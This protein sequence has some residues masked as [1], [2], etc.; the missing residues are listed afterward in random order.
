MTNKT[1]YLI[2]RYLIPL[3]LFEDFGLLIDFFGGQRD[4]KDGIIRVLHSLSF[5]D[6]PTR[7]L[8]AVRFEKRFGFKNGK[9]T[10]RLIKNTLNLGIQDKL[11]SKRLLTELKLILQEQDPR[12]CLRR[13]D[14]LDILKVIHPA[15]HLDKKNLRIMV[16]TSLRTFLPPSIRYRGIPK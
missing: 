15:L 3:I 10:L 12:D 5:I 16:S 1:R 11:S 4:L 9:H 6:D 14:E 2:F 8:R 7:I 13:L